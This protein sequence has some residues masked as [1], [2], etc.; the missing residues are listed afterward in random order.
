MGI[1]SASRLRGQKQFFR[2]PVY[3]TI[4]YLGTEVG[5]QELFE[6][7]ITTAVDKGLLIDM[8]SNGDDVNYACTTLVTD[9]QG[10]F[11]SN[12]S[13]NKP[14]NNWD[15]SNVINM[16]RMFYYLSNFNQP[17][18]NW[19]VRKV[20]RIRLLFANATNFNQPLNSWELQSIDAVARVGSDTSA[21]VNATNFNQPLNNWDVSKFGLINFFLSSVSYNQDLSSWCVSQFSSE[22]YR[23]SQNTP[24]WNLPKPIWGT[25]P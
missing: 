20:E 21:F 25:C 3:N 12:F 6:G 2:D 19:D 17:I 23:F 10:L 4:K 7:N 11:N 8:I 22:P 24:S 14:I 18:D 16:E 1:I 9:M 13:F 15:V 5:Y